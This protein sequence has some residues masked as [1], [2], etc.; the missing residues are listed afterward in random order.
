MKKLIVAAGVAALFAVTAAR[1]DDCNCSASECASN[2]ADSAATTR[3]NWNPR[4]Y[5]GLGGSYTRASRWSAFENYNDGS[6]TSISR[7]DEGP[8]YRIFVGVSFPEHLGLEVGYTKAAETTFDAQSDGSKALWAAGPVH[9]TQSLQTADLSLLAH[10]NLTPALSPFARVG[11]NWLRSSGEAFGNT[12][13]FGTYQRQGHRD[14]MEASFG[15]GL[16][17]QT[18]TP[19]RLRMSYDLLTFNNT[20]RPGGRDETADGLTLSLGYALR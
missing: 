5:A 20:Y 19:W 18:R 11:V 14:S 4:M 2:K 10:F 9:E 13:S 7:N 12:Q 6:Y 8:G 17:Y 16:E 3:W 1:A 15:A